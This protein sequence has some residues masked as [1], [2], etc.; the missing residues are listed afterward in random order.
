MTLNA[1]VQSL[2]PPAMVSLFILDATSIGGPVLRFTLGKILEGPVMYDGQAYTPTDVSFTGLETSGVGAL[3]TPKLT[4]SN[5]NGVWQAILNAYGDL[6][7]CTITRIRTLR[8]YLDDGSAPDPLAYW[9]P[10]VFRI[11][12]RTAENA[13]YIE[14]EL[15]AAIDQEGK[16]L[17]GRQVIRETCLWRYRAYN[18]AT[19]SFD[20]SKALCPYV[21]STY[22]DINDQVVTDPAED[23]PSRRLSCCKVRFGAGNPLPFGGFPGAGRSR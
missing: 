15:S 22:Y 17:P 19:S 6:L 7:G 21:G 5:T 8:K 18:E 23:V 11:E 9:G 13:V 4:L 1:E 12:R 20:Y 3:P 14:W 10:D 2:S 16:L